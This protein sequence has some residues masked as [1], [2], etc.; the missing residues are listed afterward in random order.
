MKQHQFS[1][2]VKPAFVC[3]EASRVPVGTIPSRHSLSNSVSN[4]MSWQ[5]E[6][7]DSVAQD[8]QRGPPTNRAPLPPPPSP[9]RPCPPPLLNPYAEDQTVPAMFN[10]EFNVEHRRW[11]AVRADMG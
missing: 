2:D 4:V 7:C 11:A 8:I 6:H 3:W 1:A 9:P 5:G 10:F